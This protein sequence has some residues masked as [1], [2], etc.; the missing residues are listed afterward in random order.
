MDLCRN[1]ERK[2]ADI[3]TAGL[4]I[5]W[6]DL[7]FLL[8]QNH[9]AA[10]MDDISGSFLLKQILPCNILCPFPLAVMME[11]PWPFYKLICT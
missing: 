1:P 7:L 2:A 5:E 6:T 3:K 9:T 11:Y 8:L 10:D 4:S